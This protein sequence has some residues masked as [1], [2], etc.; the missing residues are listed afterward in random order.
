MTKKEKFEKINEEFTAAKASINGPADFIPIL[1]KIIFTMDEL[2][3]DLLYPENLPYGR[4]V[5]F[6]SENF[7]AILMN[8][9]PGQSSYIHDHGNSFGVV[10]VLTDGGNNVAYDENYNYLGTIPLNPGAF[11]E[12]PKGIYHRIENPTSEYSVTLHFYAPPL[13]G[14]KVID[15]KDTKRQFIVKNESGAWEPGQ[16]EIEKVL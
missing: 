3:E 10:Y 15:Q 9:K 2:R 4:N 1:K 12:V 7:E 16:D 6:R 5:I 11:V 14:M 8:W 13:Q